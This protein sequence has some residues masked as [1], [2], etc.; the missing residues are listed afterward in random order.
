MNR[1]GAGFCFEGLLNEC[2]GDVGRGG[3]EATWP[4]PPRSCYFFFFATFFAGFF[5]AAFF[6]A[7]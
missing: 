2:A 3:E 5:A 4:S 6:V 1:E 7:I